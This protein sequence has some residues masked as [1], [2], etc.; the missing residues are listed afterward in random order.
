MPSVVNKV[1]ERLLSRHV[2]DGPWSYELIIRE[3]RP[4]D[5]GSIIHTP[6][7]YLGNIRSARLVY[8]G[9]TIICQNARRDRAAAEYTP[10]IIA[11]KVVRGV[12]A[13]LINERIK[14][15]WLC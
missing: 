6:L 3:W 2:Q 9:W 14:S 11:I 7:R 8:G 5:N 10:D 4:P 1:R 12:K 13:R 15:L